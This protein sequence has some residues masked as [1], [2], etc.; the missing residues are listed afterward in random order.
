VTKPRTLAWFSC[1]IASAVA[2]K[3]AV[4]SG[5]CE[6][7]Y[8]DTL[9]YE[10]PDNLRF[11]RDVSAW[12]GQEIKIIKSDKYTDIFD[13]FNKT[14]W[15]VGPSGAR[16]TTELKK[17]VRRAYEKPD[18]THVFGF[19]FDEAHRIERLRQESPELYVRFPLHERGLTKR[20]CEQL[21]VKASIEIPAMYRLGYKNNNCVGCVKGGAGYWNNIKRDFPEAFERMA[22]QERLMGVNILSSKA[23]GKRVRFFL[24]ELPPDM[25]RGIKEPDI[26][27]G[28]LCVHEKEQA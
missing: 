19:T 1:G 5:A 15:L 8:C 17:N 14:G 7:L 4:E 11:L 26:E 12:I 20:D 28:V 23:G 24:D 27:C 18:D 21:I 3:I 2:A 25:G 22:K 13:V 6:V 16:C 9:K 10:H